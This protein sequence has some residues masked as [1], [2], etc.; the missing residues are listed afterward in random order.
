M[1]ANKSRLPLAKNALRKLR[2]L[3]HPGIIKVLDSVETETYIYIAIE[4]VVPL[5]WHVRR[6]SLSEETTKWGLYTVANTLR[7]INE[8][9]QSVHGNLR[10]SSIFTTE[11]GEWKVGGLETLS[12]MKEEDALIYSYGN[13]VPDIMHYTPPEVSRSTWAA[14]KSNPVSAVDSYQYGLL[15]FEAFNGGQQPGEPV[16][17]TKNVP[18]TMHQCFKR[19]LS[20]NPKSRLSI[21]HFLEQGRRSGGFFETP[22]I[23]LSE[24]LENL[25]LKSD[26]ERIE[27][28]G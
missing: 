11:S 10:V 8:E 9:A 13:A 14:I 24:G 26:A 4:R 23:R 15:I 6:K 28:L 5:G 20:P 19:L 2:T 12:S 22:L 21:S 17:Q 7:F 3:R 25:G 18:P 27:L 1:T 16:A